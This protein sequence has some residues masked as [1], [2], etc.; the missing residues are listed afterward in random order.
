[1]LIIIYDKRLKFLNFSMIFFEYEKVHE[2]ITNK[3][4]KNVHAQI[5]NLEIRLNNYNEA[6]SLEEILIKQF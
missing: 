1:M 5:V 2:K 6:N 4:T 3:S